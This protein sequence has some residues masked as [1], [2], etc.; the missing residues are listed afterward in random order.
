MKPLVYIAAPY[1]SDPTGNTNSALNVAVSMMDTGYITPLVPHLSLLFDLVHP[2]P[3]EQWLAYDR[4]LLAHC[5]AL[6]RI[7]G[8]SPG[9]DAE[10]ALA[11]A[12]GIPVF[13]EWHRLCEWAMS[14]RDRKAS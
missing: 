1:S 7:N 8:E 12:L 4:E 3:Y 9:A 5:D 13:T 2:R 14:F 11:H 6:H 10:V